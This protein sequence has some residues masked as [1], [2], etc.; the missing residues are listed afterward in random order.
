MLGTA[1][2]P[3]LAGPSWGAAWLLT[4]VKIL[5]V[6]DVGFPPVSSGCDGAGGGEQ[7]GGEQEDHGA[8]AARQGQGAFIGVIKL[9]WCLAGAAQGP[10]HDHIGQSRTVGGGGKRDGPVRI[11]L[12]GADHRLVELDAG[13]QQL[14]VEGDQGRGAALLRA[15]VAEL[16]ICVGPPAVRVAVLADSQGMIVSCAG[17][18]CCEPGAGAALACGRRHACGGVPVAGGVVAEL[19]IVVVPPCPGCAVLVDGQRV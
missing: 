6:L 19:A 7:P 14:G 16:A 3:W 13:D 18:C 5:G 8:V 9:G 12:Q 4:R 17:S 10:V 2:P 1:G 11:L 15:S